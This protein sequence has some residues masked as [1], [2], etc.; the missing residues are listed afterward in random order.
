M[1]GDDAPQ[2]PVIVIARAFAPEA[3]TVANELNKLFNAVG[4]IILLVKLHAKDIPVIP[5][6]KSACVPVNILPEVVTLPIVIG[7]IVLRL[8][9]PL[10]INCV[11]VTFDMFVMLG[12]VCKV[13]HE[14]NMY[15][16]FVRAEVVLNVGKVFRPE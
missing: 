7:G 5:T 12:A 16:V 13:P 10:N 9:Q 2:F 3:P 4:P 1:L 14:S 15:D 8:Q 6:D 11:F